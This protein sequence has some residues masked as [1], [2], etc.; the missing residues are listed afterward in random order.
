MNHR[1]LVGVGLTMATRYAREP[2]PAAQGVA[3]LQV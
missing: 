2:P 1:L 3:P